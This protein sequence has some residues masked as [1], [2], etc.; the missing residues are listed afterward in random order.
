MTWQLKKQ[1]YVD[2]RYYQ[3]DTYEFIK[4][5]QEWVF[6]ADAVTY[7]LEELKEIVRR[8]DELNKQ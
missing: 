5:G 6:K 3:Y 4:D 8:I 7:D 1:I 2:N